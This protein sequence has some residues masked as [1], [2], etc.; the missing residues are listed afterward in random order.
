VK[1]GT[2]EEYFRHAWESSH[3]IDFRIRAEATGEHVTFYI[4]PLGKDGVTAD[5]D[6]DGNTLS[7]R[8]FTS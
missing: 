1:V 4:H 8:A 7:V 3:A 2:L 6:V 5:F